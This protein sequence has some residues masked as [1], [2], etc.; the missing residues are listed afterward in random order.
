MRIEKC[1][2][3]SS[4]SYPGHGLIFVRNDAKIFRFCR[5]KCHKAFK[6]KKNP[7]KTKWTKSFRRITGKEMTV[8]NCLNFEKKIE[9]PHRYDRENFVKAVD[10]IKNVSEVKSRRELIFQRN[11][12]LKDKELETKSMQ[13]RIEKNIIFTNEEE[14]KVF[15]KAKEKDMD[16][17]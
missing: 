6:A 14:R 15:Q 5:S 4:P 17:N 7:R 1:H 16:K 13:K 10:A 3:C 9:V 8:D 12:L 2:F 11:R